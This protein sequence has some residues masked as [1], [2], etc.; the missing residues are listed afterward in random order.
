MI[1]IYHILVTVLFVLALPLLPFVWIV[2]EKRRANLLQ[3]L[4]LK[5]GIPLK[6]KG[7]RRIWVHALSVG[8]VNS[9]VP[10]VTGLKKRMP[11]AQIVFTASTRTGYDTARR[12]MA[13]DRDDSPVA[14]IGYFPF[15]LWISVVL[16]YTRIAPD[17]VCLIE[18][19]LWPGFLS[20]MK[21][22]TVPVH[23][24][25]ARLSDRS[26]KGYLKLGRFAKLFFSPLSHVMA[27]TQKDALGFQTLGIS[28]SRITVAG[29]IKFDQPCIPM[30]DATMQVMKKRFG[31]Q[32]GQTVWI[33]G[34]THRGEEEMMVEAFLKVKK[35]LP[36]IKLIIAPRDPARSRRLMASLP[37]PHNRSAC[38][39]DDD[40]Q[41]QQ[42]DIV[43]IDTMGELARA[44]GICD[45]AFIGGSLVERGGHNPLEPAMFGKPVI[46]GPHMTDFREVA[47]LLV[48]AGGAIQVETPDRLDG[49]VQALLT[50][51]G[52]KDQ[53]GAAAGEVFL[54][55]S[56]AVDRTLDIITG[57]RIA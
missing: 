34:S 18:T 42:A 16:I 8:E 50:D 28:A 27:Q 57:D 41:K 39:S 1:I 47:G 21:R 44:Y 54:N 15:D 12:L 45:I 40:R 55:N 22:R 35:T 3:R 53:M 25:N 5:T 9:S 49:Q 4:G 52:Q 17:L 19:D 30:D 2:S 51:S 43:F 23:L 56:G 36:E 33:A 29:N 48:N 10:F 31:I 26:L 6:K 32:Q 37:I 46:F 38:L 14:V 13:V 7:D 20:I 11:G 24:I